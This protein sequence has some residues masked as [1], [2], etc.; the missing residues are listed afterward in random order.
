MLVERNMTQK[1]LA[2]YL[3]VDPV[4]LNRYITGER[5]IPEPILEK[6]A[7]FFNVEPQ[8]LLGTD[9]SDVLAWHY[10]RLEA[11]INKAN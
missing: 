11:Q 3:E 9:D 8:E 10:H 1:T 4:T 5:R 7:D 6:L 2:E